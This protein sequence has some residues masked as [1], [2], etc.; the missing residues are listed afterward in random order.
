MNFQ[1]K[2]LEEKNRQSLDMECVEED[3]LILIIS[4]SNFLYSPNVT[5]NRGLDRRDD[6]P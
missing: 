5:I 4:L 2:M 1:N 6:L 3:K